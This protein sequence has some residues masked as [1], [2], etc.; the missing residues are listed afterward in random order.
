[1]PAF[2]ASFGSEP[3]LP[4]A[5][6]HHAYRAW[7]ERKLSAHPRR[8][9]ELLVEIADPAALS[10]REHAA[11][12]D[13]LKRVNLAVYACRR[14]GA[15]TK[16][17][18][19]SLGAQ[20]GLH[21]LDANMCA[22]EDSISSIEVRGEGLKGGYIP[23]SD[24]PINWHTDGYYNTGEH[25]IRAMILHCARPAAEG[26][27][28]ALLDHEMAYI[29]LRDEDPALVEALMHP[30]AMAIPPNEMA[31]ETEE[32]E[33]RGEITGPVFSVHVQTGSL[34][35]RYTARTRSIRWR[36]DEATHRA[37][38]A[39]TRILNDESNPWMFR[40]RLEPG[41]G[42]LCNNVLHTR[43][44]FRDDPVSPRLLYRARYY[45]RIAGTGFSG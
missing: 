29:Q 37:V 36:D 33:V 23:Y 38:A 40:H 26:G 30:G 19:R 8:V 2:A 27:V 32:S 39:L 45:E 17:D 5:A 6:D 1:M 41:Q 3:A 35:L 15:V 22:D 7:R 12:L 11:L 24:R 43:S 14:P 25:Q 21:T 13:R 16:N 31:R 42:L 10:A 9:D 44:G 28:N 34:H 20:M 4:W 18:L